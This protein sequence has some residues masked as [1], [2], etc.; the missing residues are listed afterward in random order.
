MNKFFKDNGF[1][2]EEGEQLTGDFRSALTKLFA[3]RD[4]VHKM[5]VS[6]LQSLGANLAKMVGDAVSKQI[7]VLDDKARNKAALARKLADMTDEQFYAFM[8]AKY[9]DRWQLVSITDEELERCPRMSEEQMQKVMDEA[10]A[11]RQAVIAGTPIVM[12]DPKL[13][14]K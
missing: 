8:T 14:F 3:R 6:E 2:S 9:G 13:R 7:Q 4:D 11:I 10:L 12:V 5:S 1:L